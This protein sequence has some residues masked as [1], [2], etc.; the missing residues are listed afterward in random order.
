MAR[1]GGYADHILVPDAKY[2][3]DITGLDP[4]WAATMACSGLTAYSAVNKV[5]PLPIDEPIVVIGAGGV[6][7][8]AVATLKALGHKRIC[9]VDVSQRNLDIA[10]EL[11]ASDVVQPGRQGV[12]ADHRGLRGSGR[13]RHR[14][15]QQRHHRPRAHST[16]CARVDSWCKSV[17][18]VESSSSRPP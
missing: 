9:V 11:G 10:T 17:C 14:L 6:G 7:L 8:T 1:H 4:S 5:L 12:Q 2:L 13:G 18:S 15:R 3:V 16:P